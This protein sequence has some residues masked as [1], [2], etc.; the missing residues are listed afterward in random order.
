[1]KKAKSAR[2][3][4]CLDEGETKVTNLEKLLKE[5]TERP[6]IRRGE[7]VVTNRPM[8]GAY[9]ETSVGSLER[10]LAERLTNARLI[11]LAVN[12]LGECVALLEDALNPERDRLLRERIRALLASIEEEAGR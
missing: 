5:A 7:S 9:N 8:L 6:W 3:A 2:C 10:P 11:A 1:L 12:R 4:R